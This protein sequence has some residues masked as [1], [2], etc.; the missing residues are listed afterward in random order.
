MGWTMRESAG[1]ILGGAVTTWLTPWFGVEGSAAWSGWGVA[2]PTSRLECEGS[3][4]ARNFT[5]RSDATDCVSG[6]DPPISS[7]GAVTLLSGRVL[8]AAP[9]S[10][11]ASAYVSAGV[12]SIKREG[13]GTDRGSTAYLVGFTIP[14]SASAVFG[15]GMR[16]PIPRAHVIWRVELQ[17]YHYAIQVGSPGGPYGVMGERT[18]NDLVLVTGPSFTVP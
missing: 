5:A 8:L 12:A 7:G 2:Y 1:V 13:I 10:A 3:F 9:L 4:F 17:D 16:V 14:S 6:W 18:Q 15:A 11:G